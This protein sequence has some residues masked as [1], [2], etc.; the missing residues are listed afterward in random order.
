[1]CDTVINRYL[2]DDV[3]QARSRKDSYY[4]EVAGLSKEGT[5]VFVD[6]P[7]EDHRQCMDGRSAEV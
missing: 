4:T 6:L 1:M 7:R 3:D 5:Q 2:L